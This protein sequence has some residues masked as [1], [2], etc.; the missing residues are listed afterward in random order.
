M[1]SYFSVLSTLVLFSAALIV[2]CVLY[3]WPGFVKRHGASVLLAASA[4]AAVRLILPLEIPTSLLVRSWTLLGPSLRVL[5]A[6]PTVVRWVVTVWVVGAAVMVGWDVFVFTLAR[7]RCRSYVVV[8][9]ERVRRCAERLNV[10]CPVLVSTDVEVPYVAGVFHPT[11]Y[12][13]VLELSE[14]AIELI[15]AHEAEH[16]R[17]HD[18]V[19]KFFFGIAATVL[20]WN[21][22]LHFFRRT[23]NALIEMRCDAKVT[24]HMDEVG[25]LAYVTALKDVAAQV[26]RGR[27]FPALA[28][29]E[30]HAVGKKTVL[31]R[32]AELLLARKGKPPQRVSPAARCVLAALFI[33]SYLVIVQSAGVPPAEV[34]EEK[35][36]IYYLDD[37]DGSE[38]GKDK[39]GHFI[40]RKTDGR[41]ELYVDYEFN[42]YLTE[43][44]VASERYNHLPVFEEDKQE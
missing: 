37:F 43:A 15:L 20:W 10:G 29:D 11:I 19:V 25:R 31:Q 6:N 1:V 16:I 44:E 32:R 8:E 14:D 4:C 34:F 33:A 18:A 30:F 39:N 23:V 13:P 41:H 38:V 24:E 3:A 27:R 36:G 5:R 40:I 2:V 35:N 12:F 22:L 26:V 28:L 42:R 21:P 7:R 17:A 9:D